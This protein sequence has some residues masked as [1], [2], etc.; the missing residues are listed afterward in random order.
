MDCSTL[1]LGQKAADQ[2]DGLFRN[3]Q[4]VEAH[5]RRA[6]SMRMLGGEIEGG[7]GGEGA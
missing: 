3:Q 1:D 4:E 5:C 2:L 6:K 7:G